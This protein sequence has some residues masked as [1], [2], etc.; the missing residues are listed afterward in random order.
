MSDIPESE[1]LFLL[2]VAMKGRLGKGKENDLFAGYGA[3]VVVQGQHLHAG[4]LLD[5]RLHDRTGRFD[6]MGPDLFEQVPPLSASN[7]LTSCCSAAVKTPWR[8]TTKDR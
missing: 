6:Q 3:D 4:D 1:P 5:H 7:D 8:R 2:G